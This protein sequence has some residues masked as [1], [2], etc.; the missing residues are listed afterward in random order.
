MTR[1]REEPITTYHDQTARYLPG[2]VQY[3]IDLLDDEIE[4]LAGGRVPARVTEAA[5]KMLAWKREAGR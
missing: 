2:D 1:K 4:A 5:Y 3:L